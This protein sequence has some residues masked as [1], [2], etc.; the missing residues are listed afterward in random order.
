M[1]ALLSQM[2]TDL[3]SSEGDIEI[4]GRA[5]GGGDS[6][7]A[8]RAEGANMIITQERAAAEDPYL[9]AVMDDLP[10]TIL[11]IASSGSSSTSINFSRQEI[12]LRGEGAPSLA[13][14]IRKAAELA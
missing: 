5:D 10:L 3:L 9:G 12:R 2:I 8:A 6:L 4:V 7:L 14:V 1:S 11:A 13:D